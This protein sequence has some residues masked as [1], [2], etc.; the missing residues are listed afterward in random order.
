MVEQLTPQQRWN[1]K[2][3]DIL[4]EAT[5]RWREK[6]RDKARRTCREWKKRNP[7]QHSALQTKRK[8]AQLH[9][10]PKWAKL[11]AI[12]AFYIEAARKSSE[13]GIKYQVDHVIPLQGEFVSGL[14]VETNL[15][16]LTDLDN[17]KKGNKYS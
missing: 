17:L 7:A 12:A 3:K 9:R 13:T 1:R 5:R 4:R 6:N 14:H 11:D 8:A 16:I 2:N 15:Q 10:T